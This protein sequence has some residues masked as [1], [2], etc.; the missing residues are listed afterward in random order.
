MTS[1]GRLKA[2]INAYDATAEYYFQE[3]CF[4]NELANS[5]SDPD[6]S[7]A[8]A[9]VAVGGVTRWHFLKGTTERYVVLRG[10]GLVEVEGLAS[11][12]VSA[13]DVV[14]IPPDARQRIANTG[15]VDLEFLAICSPRFLPDNYVDAEAVAAL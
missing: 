5:G 15:E 4:I 6:V 8:R 3:G 1:V 2:A 13:G 9:R 12:V 11:Q 7:I 10:S 14:I